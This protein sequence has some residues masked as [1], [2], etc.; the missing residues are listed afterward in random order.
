MFNDR[1]DRDVAA[2]IRRVGIP[3]FQK[4]AVIAER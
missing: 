1:T 4:H 3:L 2:H